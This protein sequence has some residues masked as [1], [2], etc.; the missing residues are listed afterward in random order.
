MD[1]GANTMAKLLWHQLSAVAVFLFGLNLG[2]WVTGTYEGH[3]GALAAL[4]A[5]NGELPIGEGSQ[6][7][8]G[9]NERRWKYDWDLRSMVILISAGLL[10]AVLPLWI[11]TSFD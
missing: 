7:L 6:A 8:I 1:K 3:A 2:G 5:A 10:I 11:K 4:D 9:W